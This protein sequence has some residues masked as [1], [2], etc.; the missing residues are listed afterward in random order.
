[1]TLITLKTA[2]IHVDPSGVHALPLGLNVR[3]VYVRIVHNLV[4]F[5]VRCY[6]RRLTEWGSSLPDGPH[7]LTHSVG[8]TP[9]IHSSYYYHAGSTTYYTE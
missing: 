3:N 7:S 1:M 9:I 8:I 5:V 4:V 6:A 2:N